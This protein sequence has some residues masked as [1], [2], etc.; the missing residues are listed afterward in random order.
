MKVCEERTYFK[1][2]YRIEAA[3]G[4]HFAA[5]EQP[6]LFVAELRKTLTTA[7]RKGVSHG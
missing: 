5:F 6:E 7:T 4:R 3:Q 1:V 2:V